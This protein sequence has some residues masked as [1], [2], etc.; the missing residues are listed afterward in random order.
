MLLLIQKIYLAI[1][2]A[3]SYE[4][5]HLFR[6]FTITSLGFCFKTC[7]I[8]YTGYMPPPIIIILMWMGWYSCV[9]RFAFEKYHFRIHT[10]LQSCSFAILNNKNIKGRLHLPSWYV[11]CHSWFLCLPFFV[12]LKAGELQEGVLL[13]LPSCPVRISYQ[14]TK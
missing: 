2:S 10:L 11:N 1:C 4:S 8:L 13:N 6:V 14:L 7:I 3:L 9:D 5:F 12:I